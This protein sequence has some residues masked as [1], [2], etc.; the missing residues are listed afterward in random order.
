MKCEG[1]KCFCGYFG[2]H[3]WKLKILCDMKCVSFFH[4]DTEKRTKIVEKFGRKRDITGLFQWRKKS[5]GIWADSL[6]N[7]YAYST[8]SNVRAFKLS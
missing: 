7:K 6:L 8:Q 1:E 5:I 4:S 3:S 2:P